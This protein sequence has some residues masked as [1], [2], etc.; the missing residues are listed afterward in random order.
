MTDIGYTE[1]MARQRIAYLDEMERARAEA[2][3]RVWRAYGVLG[4]DLPGDAES[5]DVNH[6]I[7][8]RKELAAM[9]TALDDIEVRLPA[10]RSNV[11]GR[12]V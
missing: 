3:G 8:A 1:R 10:S 4:R 2:M 7:A 6:I 11:R 9:T 5:I 12:D